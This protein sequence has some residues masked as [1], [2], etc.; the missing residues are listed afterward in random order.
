V[1]PDRYEELKK[2]VVR[3]AEAALAHHQYVSSIDVLTG[4]GLLA[5]THVQSWR[6]G[7]IDF[8][9]RTIQ[10][11]LNKISKS[12]A[13]FHQ[14]ALE[15]GLKP[16]ETR[17]VRSTRTGKADLQFSK[18]GD[19]AIEKKYRTHYLSSAL[20]ERKQEQLTQKLSRPDQLVVFEI[21]RDSACSECGAERPGGSFLVME[22][23]QPLCL[24]CARLDELEYLPAGDTALTRRSTRHSER[25]AVVVRFS[26][27]R[28]RYE[29]QGILVEAGVSGARGPVRGLPATRGPRRRHGVG[30]NCAGP[31]RRGAVAPSQGNRKSAGNYA[32]LR[33]ISVENGN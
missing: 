25:T 18:S 6:T 1:Q 26:R 23:E 2:R 11:N 27:S 8:L 30:K 22:A 7:R 24:L 17:Y 19:P 16:S 32:R 10:A 3:A 9:E 15:R 20:W 33:Q 29:R 14:W 28:G 21:L 4:M 5:P 12:M 31:G 13:L